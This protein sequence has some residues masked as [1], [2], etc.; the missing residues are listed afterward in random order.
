MFPPLFAVLIIM[1]APHLGH[2][3]PLP[4]FSVTEF[5]KFFMCSD[6]VKACGRE[7]AR[8]D[9]ASYRFHLVLRQDDSIE[10][11][12][13][14]NI[15]DTMDHVVRHGCLESAVTDKDDNRVYLVLINSEKRFKGF[16]MFVILAQR[17]LRNLFVVL[18]NFLRP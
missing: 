12:D 17:V 3:T 9:L 2:F 7:P 16:Y 5:F 10:C 6:L 11:L 18:E 15:A 14:S 13:V 8:S 1:D 4:E